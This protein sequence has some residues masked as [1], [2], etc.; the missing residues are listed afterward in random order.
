MNTKVF[1]S[2]SMIKDE[3]FVNLPNIYYSGLYNHA[4]EY[5]KNN[6]YKYLLF[7]CSDV[8]VTE[9][10]AAKMFANLSSG[11]V[12]EIGVYSPASTGR[13]HFQCKQQNADGWRI[14]DFVEGF[15]FFA[16]MK[17][18]AA[19]S[20]IDTQLNLY[21]WGIDIV[22]GF[23]SKKMGLLS[24][25]DDGVVVHHPDSVGYSS[26]EAEDQ[27]MNWFK[28]LEHGNEIISFHENRLKL[29][30]SGLEN[31]MKI[32]VIIPCYNQ[33]N[34][35]SQ[36]VYS[37]FRQTYSNF[38]IILINDGSTD[39]TDYIADFLQKRFN[40]VKYIKQTNKGLGATRNVG[41]AHATGN[42]VQFLDADDVL[43]ENKFSTAVKAFAD[44]PELDITYS[45]YECFEDG[46]PSNKWTYSRVELT[47][48]PVTDLIEEWEK[49]LS[50]PVHCFLFKKSIIGKTL[51]DVN[52]PNHEDWAF[53]LMIAFKKPSY[54]FI[55]ESTALYRMKQIAMSQDA[56]RMKDG[57]NRCIASVIASGSVPKA[58][59]KPLYERFDYKIVIGIIS[60]KK[61][62]HKIRSIK[63][64]WIKEMQECG[65]PYYI[66][67]ADPS[68][69]SCLLIND[70]LYVPC[71]D[72]YESLPA[73]VFYFYQYVLKNTNYD[74][75]YKI[76]DDCY[77]N[78]ENLYST[79]FWNYD[80]FGKTVGLNENEL[81]RKWH[82]GK[83]E[84]P[85]LN[86]RTYELPYIGSW[87]GGGYGYFLSRKALTHIQEMESE[88]K[89][90]LYEDK[91]I[92]DVLRKNKIIPA[93]NERYRV[94]DISQQG[95]NHFDGMNFKKSIEKL[96]ISD[97][98]TIIELE[99]NFQFEMIT[100]EKQKHSSE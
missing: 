91:A 13:S 17:M 82:A 83:C 10:E 86:E 38:E 68:L 84:K 30:R 64:S 94:L 49:T 3:E 50:I 2:G 61:N 97:Y 52:L 41:I 36:C 66:V 72:N 9:K 31:S 93:E 89:T 12:G 27:M 98:E 46:D 25:I 90:E 5:A 53:H 20:T 88:V 92:G 99:E 8:I 96:S 69:T 62:E 7:I 29:I 87:C 65:L 85:E 67:I 81:N 60:C 28:T 1:D 71:Q 11:E 95:I 21:G 78:I 59:F 100:E 35:L 43:S 23:Y 63:N 55:S 39:N 73:K 74:Y 80:Y 42:Y 19:I 33:S 34:Y 51:F 47:S 79:Y 57:K 22:K 48:D 18:L 4:Y 26:F 6:N 44:N 14:V 37:V 70:T 40:Q 32:S 56:A 15:M 45:K 75:V 77:V 16:N 54:L 76:D 58:Y 24:I